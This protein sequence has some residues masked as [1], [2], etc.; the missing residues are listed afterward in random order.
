MALPKQIAQK[1]HAVTEVLDDGKENDRFRDLVDIVMLSV[2]VPPSAELRAVGAKTFYIR[3]KHGW[4]PNIVTYPDWVEPME[5]RAEEM[6]LAQKTAKEIVL[7]VRDYV[8]AIA[9]A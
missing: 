4:P 3:G 7:Y 6:G 9:I 8:Q 2:M 5:Q 1:L